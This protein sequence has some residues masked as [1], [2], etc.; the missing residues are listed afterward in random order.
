MAQNGAK[1]RSN[2]DTTGIIY[3]LLFNHVYYSLT[4]IHNYIYIITIVFLGE[5]SVIYVK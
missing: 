2:K 5:D 3:Y 4:V 1:Y